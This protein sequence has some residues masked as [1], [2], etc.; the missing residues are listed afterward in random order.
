MSNPYAHF[1]VPTVI[2]AAGKLTALGGTAQGKKVAEAQAMAAQSHVD[3]ESLRRRA[4]EIIAGITGAEAASIT[5]G[6]AAG[7]AISV[8]AAITGTDVGL[9][10]RLPDSGG[11]ANRVLL[12]AGHAV[13]FGAPVEQMIRLG[14]GQP[15]I[16]GWVNSVPEALLASEFEHSED[17]AAF[18][19]VQSHHCVQERMI[20]LPRCIELCHQ[21]GVPVL[22]DAAAE[23]DLEKYVALG[24][25]LVTYSGGKALGGPTSGFIAGRRELV[26]A[27]ELQTRGIARTMKVGKES[28]VGLLTAIEDYIQR[29]HAAQ[30][31]RH[32]L[33]NRCLVDALT[34]FADT[35]DVSIRGDEAGRAI[36]RVAVRARDASFDVRDLVAFLRDGNPSVRTR[37]HHL[38]DGVVLFDP[39]EVSEEQAR[40]V[41]KRLA[42]FFERTS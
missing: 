1:K 5:T 30:T 4:G 25:D 41:A 33:V 36:E 37:N 27:C 38:D 14:G 15:Q 29:D 28:I 9:V 39:R 18:V 11:L 19:F 31:E 32:V 42:E 8:A 2:N 7:V 35:A 6:A 24:V 34:P 13:N 22:L 21:H 40:A 3:L 10:H 20:A 12:Q 26:E 23:E 16:V 17:V